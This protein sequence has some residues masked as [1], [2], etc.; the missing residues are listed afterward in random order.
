M[1]FQE[2]AGQMIVVPAD[3]QER[4]LEMQQAATQA[5]VVTIMVMTDLIIMTGI[6]EMRI[7]ITVGTAE[8]IVLGKVNQ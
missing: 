5:T 6:G 7:L 2:S 8:I 3:L 4:A 1:M